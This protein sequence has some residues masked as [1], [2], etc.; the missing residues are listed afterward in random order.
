M[1]S[2]S[3]ASGPGSGT[4]VTSRAQ[5][6]SDA[7]NV[8]V[9]NTLTSPYISNQVC[10][11]NVCAVRDEEATSSN[12]PYY[13]RKPPDTRPD[14]PSWRRGACSRL[15]SYVVCSRIIRLKPVTLSYGF[16]MPSTRHT[17]RRV[18]AHASST[19]APTHQSKAGR[20][21]S[22]RE[23]EPYHAAPRSP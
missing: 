1:V 13:D 18:T 7:V 8:A 3:P 6:R 17:W 19:E 23:E 9:H 22:A 14:Q 15:I 16:F 5:V 11:S 10:Y 4:G 20:A 21:R 12:L 2:L